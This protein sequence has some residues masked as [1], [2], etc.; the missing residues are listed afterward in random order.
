MIDSL[1]YYCGTSRRLCPKPDKEL[2][3][4]VVDSFLHVSCAIADITINVL[5][6]EIAAT[7]YAVSAAQKRSWTSFLKSGSII[8]KQVGHAVL[9]VSL[10]SGETIISITR[11]K[12]I[13]PGTWHT[14]CKDS[15]NGA[16]FHNV[17]LPKDEITV[18]PVEEQ[19][20]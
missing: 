12:T 1:K 16:A 20:E 14:S 17:T 10:P 4:L 18:A 5:M 3:S 15:H 9:T 13:S 11:A 19:G 6:L 2:Q 8:M 7:F